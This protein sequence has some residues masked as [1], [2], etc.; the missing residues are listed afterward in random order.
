MYAFQY[1][2]CRIHIKCT[3]SDMHVWNNIFIQMIHKRSVR[4]LDRIY[5]TVSENRKAEI[6][7]AGS[8]I[9]EEWNCHSTINLSSWYP[10]VCFP[11]LPCSTKED[12]TVLNGREWR[13]KPKWQEK[14][15]KILQRRR[16]MSQEELHIQ[17]LFHWFTGY[18][19][20]VT[21]LLDPYGVLRTFSSLRTFMSGIYCSGK[22]VH[23]NTSESEAITTLF[24]CPMESFSET[25]IKPQ[26]FH[27]C[28]YFLLSS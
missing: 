26:G 5:T 19:Q 8:F 16:A 1:G 12:W 23:Q 20:S 11:S 22:E 25:Q 17:N 3:G 28:P 24:F 27:L 4:P 9:Y 15:N 7:L 6:Y 14:H 21:C 2:K 18:L 10:S 13:K